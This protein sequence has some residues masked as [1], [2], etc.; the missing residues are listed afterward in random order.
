MNIE[1]NASETTENDRKKRDSFDVVNAGDRLSKHAVAIGALRALMPESPHRDEQA[2]HEIAALCALEVHTELLDRFSGLHTARSR[3]LPI[4]V[5]TAAGTSNLEVPW[6]NYLGRVLAL[7]NADKRMPL[8]EAFVAAVAKRE[9]QK[10]AG[11]QIVRVEAYLGQVMCKIC[12]HACSLDIAVI[13]GGCAV[14]VEQKVNSGESNWKCEGCMGHQLENYRRL[15]PDWTRGSDPTASPS[16]YRYCYLTP[17]GKKSGEDSDQDRAWTAFTHHD[18]AKALAP[19]IH[20]LDNFAARW[21]AATFVI[22]LLSSIGSGGGG[23]QQTMAAV[24]RWRDDLDS[25]AAALQ[26]LS[27]LNNDAVILTVLEEIG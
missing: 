9:P 15:F 24:E 16:D 11:S 19:A 1:A 7:Q 20:Q 2:L 12:R 14:A 25:P 18:V 8:A 26:L 3:D 27:E 23:L 5:L 21:S 17:G 10:D 4:P 22:D 6:T 13:S